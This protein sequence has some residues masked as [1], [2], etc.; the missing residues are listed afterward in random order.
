L[1]YN[2]LRHDVTSLLLN[3][4]V[5]GTVVSRYLGPRAD[6]SVTMGVYVHMIDGTS[7]MAAAGMDEVL[8]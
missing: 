5:P 8:A 6:P 1:H 3:Q 2:N 4:S 7:G